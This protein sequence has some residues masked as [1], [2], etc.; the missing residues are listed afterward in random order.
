MTAT[1]T[2]IALTSDMFTAIAA[3]AG[4]R[5]KG[6][7]LAR[8]RGFSNAQIAEACGNAG[9]A[10]TIA[11]ALSELRKKHGIKGTAANGWGL[12]ALGDAL[13]LEA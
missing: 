4:G 13:G 5:H 3:E 8:L 11:Y 12:T 2:T 7:V 1:T 6:F 9:G 10:P